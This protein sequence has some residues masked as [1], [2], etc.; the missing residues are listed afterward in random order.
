MKERPILF[1]GVMVRAILEG[2]KTQTRR[3]IPFSTNLLT[4]DSLF[5]NPN[6]IKWTDGFG[7]TS[8]GSV[9]NVREV[10]CRYGKPGDRLWVRETFKTST[11]GWVYKATSQHDHSNDLLPWKPSIFMPRHASR[12]TLKI[13]NIR[14]ERLND[15]SEEDAKAEGVCDIPKLL[16]AEEN[17]FVGIDKNLFIERYRKLWQSINGSGSWEKN[18]WV[19]VV[20]FKGV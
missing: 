8:N 19:W 4:A 12:I 9:M 2:R 18:P 15:I 1:S 7:F 3:I 13:T 10:A 20:E 5:K 14:V 16:S 17:D 6:K 11:R